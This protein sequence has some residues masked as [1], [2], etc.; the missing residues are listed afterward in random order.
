[1]YVSDLLRLERERSRDRDDCCRESFGCTGGENY[2]SRRAALRDHKSK[3]DG[4]PRRFQTDQARIIGANDSLDQNCRSLWNT[5][6]RD[7][8]SKARD[9][10]PVFFV[11]KK[12][13]SL[14]G[15]LGH[16][17]KDRSPFI[18]G[19]RVPE[20][21]GCG[22]TEATCEPGDGKKCQ[23]PTVSSREVEFGI[24]TCCKKLKIQIFVKK[25][26][27]KKKTFEEFQTQVRLRGLW[28]ARA[29]VKTREM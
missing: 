2:K 1:M 8:P 26:R 4:A 7:D 27:K 21:A 24:V 13:G 5:V 6:V 22:E 15:E 23:A 20:F 17:S 18:I 14:R 25:K 28:A 12:D 9:W 11:P 16:V 10:V 29:F 3:F 19:G